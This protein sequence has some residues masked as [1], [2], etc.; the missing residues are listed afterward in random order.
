[1]IAMCLV[2]LFDIS[3]FPHLITP[4]PQMCSHSRI[5][6]MISLASRLKQQKHHTEFDK[7]KRFCTYM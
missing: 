4:G 5:E 7:A 2:S 1:M 6:K 3:N